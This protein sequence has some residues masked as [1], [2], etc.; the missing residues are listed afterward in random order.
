MKSIDWAAAKGARV[1]NMSFAGPRESGHRAATGG[2]LQENVTLVAAAGNAGPKSPPLYPAA[3]RHVIAVAA[4]DARDEVFGLSNRGDY[5]AVAAP[6]VDIIAPAPRGAY[7]ITSG[8]SVAA[9]YV[10]GLADAFDRALA[11]A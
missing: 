1:I 4:T 2:R 9:A 10:S 3:D 8:T 6:G 7:Q 11:Q 5:I